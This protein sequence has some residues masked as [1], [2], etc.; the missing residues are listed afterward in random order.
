MLTGMF[1][2]EQEVSVFSQK[3]GSLLS[4][5]SHVDAALTHTS[6]PRDTAVIKRHMFSHWPGTE[7]HL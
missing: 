6:V 7:S 4:P 2:K 3:A 1:S 5:L